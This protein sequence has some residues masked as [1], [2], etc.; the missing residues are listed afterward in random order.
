[1]SPKLTPL[2]PGRHRLEGSL[3]SLRGFA[4]GKK[5]DKEAGGGS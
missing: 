1:M 5:T 3:R 4:T 2:S